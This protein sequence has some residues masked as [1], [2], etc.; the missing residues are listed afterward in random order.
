MLCCCKAVLYKWCA[1]NAEPARKFH[2]IDVSA[3]D[4]D[5]SKS[6]HCHL[7]NL[8]DTLLRIDTSR[9]VY[10]LD[11]KLDESNRALS[12]ARKFAPTQSDQEPDCSVPVETHVV[13]SL[14]IHGR[15][16]FEV[17]DSTCA[18]SGDG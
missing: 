1:S 4:Q 9:A 15:V 7:G 3:G 17:T 2:L 8:P 12:A 13:V 16:Q 14:Q 11:V 6:H 5:F 10:V 18:S